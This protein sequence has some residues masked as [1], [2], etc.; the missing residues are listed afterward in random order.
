GPLTIV[1]DG[2]GRYPQHVEAAV[3]FSCLEAL[4][5][6]AKYAE[7]TSVTI[8]LSSNDELAFEIRDAGRGFDTTATSLGSGLLGI[9]DRVAA[10]GGLSTCAR[11]PVEGPRSPGGFPPNRST[12]SLPSVEGD[13]G[14]RPVR[15]SA[16]GRRVP[17]RCRAEGT[18]QDFASR[19]RHLDQ[20]DCGGQELGSALV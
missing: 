6:V 1:A 8:R 2:V 16:G 17:A 7:A 13:T 18:P 9:A 19:R 11:H 14:L 5:N 3:Y 10:T 15:S 4:Q 12:S 20:R